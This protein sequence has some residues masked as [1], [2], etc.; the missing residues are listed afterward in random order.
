[1]KTQ[2]Y[3]VAAAVVSVAG[4]AQTTM[5]DAILSF[6]YTDLSGQY[7]GDVLG[8]LFT[9]RA[10]SL[11]AIQTSGDVTRLVPS[12]VGTATFNTGFEGGLDASD[13]VFNISVFDKTAN[14]AMGLGEFVLTDIDGDTISGTIDGIWVRG[15]QGRTFFNGNLRNVVLTD[16]GLQDNTF[17]GNDGAF[18]ISG[19]GGP[20]P[21]LEGALVQLFIRTGV[22]FFDVSFF[23][24]STQVSGEIVPTP[25][26]VALAGLAGIAALRRR[27]A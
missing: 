20:Q 1:M 21:V 18:Q 12:G 5:A 25:G 2:K 10:S 9:A 22:G 7:V 17:N 26:A 3:L 14:R 23:N 19:L 4:V 8:G 11:G 13:A 24:N 16:N 27:R 15:S 6:G